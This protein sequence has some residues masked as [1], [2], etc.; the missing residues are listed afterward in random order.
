MYFVRVVLPYP[1]VQDGGRVRACATYIDQ[2]LTSSTGR[3]DNTEWLKNN[4]TA[5]LLERCR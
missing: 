5:A 4:V 1:A 2:P 3:D